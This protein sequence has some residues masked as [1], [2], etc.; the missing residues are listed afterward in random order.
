M[1]SL[2][3]VGV[4]KAASTVDDTQVPAPGV[5]CP[6]SIIGLVREEICTLDATCVM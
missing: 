2:F 1:V 3:G 4:L 6:I 5:A